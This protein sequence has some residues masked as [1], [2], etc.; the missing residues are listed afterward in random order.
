MPLT[1]YIATGNAGKLKEFAEAA[2]PSGAR[3]L[4]L[5]GL[6]GIPTPR[7]DQPTF[8]GNARA[9]AVYYSSTLPG[10]VVL[11]DDSGL[12]AV[13]LGGA[14]GVRS[15]RY[16]ADAGFA[17]P[18]LTTDASNNLLLLR[19]LAG[20]A[21]RGARYVCA[22]AAARDAQVIAL[23]EGTV[24]GRILAAPQGGGGFGYDPLFYLPE[25]GCSMA[26]LSGEEKWTLSH[27]GRAFRALLPLL[28]PA[29]GSR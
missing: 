16:A 29:P 25:R 3:V 5:P 11:A 27:R 19:E 10:A 13:G 28:Q 23:A 17:P 15:A 7:E 14:P 21:D 8:A 26:E 1:L 6:E 9:K 12:E 2:G 20:V 4:P 22:L 24:E 18:G